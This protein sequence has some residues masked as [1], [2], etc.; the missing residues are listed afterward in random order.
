MKPSTPASDTYTVIV[1]LSNGRRLEVKRNPVK[2]SKVKHD[3]DVKNAAV[4]WAFND[5]LVFAAVRRL[6]GVVSV[7]WEQKNP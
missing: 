4:T 7:E 2:D 6:P 3:V 5:H 1:P